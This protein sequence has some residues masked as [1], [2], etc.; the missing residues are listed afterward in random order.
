MASKDTRK[1]GEEGLETLFIGFLAI[2]VII[3]LLLGVSI[4]VVVLPSSQPLSTTYELTAEEAGE[5]TIDFIANNVVPA[6]IWVTLVNVEEVE[7]ANLY[8]VAINLSTVEASETRELYVTKDG[9]MLFPGVIDMSGFTI[10]NFVVSGDPPCTEDQKPIVYFFGSEGCSAC[11]WEH[12]LLENV[13]SKFEGYISFHDN[14]NNLDADKE[15]FDKYNPQ[16]SVP[17]LVLGCSYYRVGAGV[18]IGADQEEKI[19]TALLC[20]LTDNKPEA[21]CHDPE[22]EALIH[23]V[24]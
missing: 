17:T 13:T 23:Q 19:L 7:N 12:P 6:G 5:K 20:T 16:N 14:M 15:I 18:L 2:G 11:K 1:S 3:G 10:G 9:K 8:K 24:G 22:I 4:G 21:V